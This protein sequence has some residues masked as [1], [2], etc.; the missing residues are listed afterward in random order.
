MITSEPP[1]V[2]QD[3][4]GHHRHTYQAIFRHPSA[5]NVQWHDVRAR[6]E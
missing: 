6:A 4:N 5:H 1:N 2:P 3:L